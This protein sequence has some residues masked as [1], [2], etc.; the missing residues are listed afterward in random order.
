M[1]NKTTKPFVLLYLALHFNTTQMSGK[2][3]VSTESLHII[4]SIQAVCTKCV[5]ACSSWKPR[6]S[7]LLNRGQPKNHDVAEKTV[8]P[9]SILIHR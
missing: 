4:N 5:Y 6:E 9:S 7:C 1:Q 2:I 8:K 3:A